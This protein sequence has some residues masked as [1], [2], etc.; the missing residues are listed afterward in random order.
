MVM[1][2]TNGDGN[3]PP[4]LVRIA[5]GLSPEQLNCERGGSMRAKIGFKSF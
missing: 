1:L 3:G 4:L 5:I 2:M